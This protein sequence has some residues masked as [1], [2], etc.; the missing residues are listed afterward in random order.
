MAS[1]QK[2]RSEHLEQGVHAS[3]YA[4][5]RPDMHHAIDEWLKTA[6]EH[7]KRGMIRLARAANPQLLGAI[8]VKRKG[9]PLA[10][11]IPY[12]LHPSRKGQTAHNMDNGQG[13]SQMGRSR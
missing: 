1:T 2:G 13:S 11:E 6:G 4:L 5:V 7:E 8:Q 12:H 9:L 3:L 10:S